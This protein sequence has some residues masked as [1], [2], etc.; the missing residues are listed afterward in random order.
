MDLFIFSLVALSASLHVL[1]N[2]FVKQS[3]DKMA[4]TY[5]ASIAGAGIV[6][7]IFMLSRMI[8]PGP[9]GWNVWGWAVLS[10]LFETLY[11][12]LLYQAYNKADIS[13]VYPLSRGTAP[14]FTAIIGFWFVGDSITV[15][16]GAAILVTII[17]VIS[18]SFSAYGIRMRRYS[19]IG[20]LPAVA[21][22]GM[23]ASYHLVDR[24]VMGS[25]NHPNSL[26]YFCI[27]R[28]FIAGF[29]TI[30]IMLRP[31]CYTIIIREWLTNKSGVIIAS[32]GIVSGYYLIIFALQYGNVTYITASRNIG[33][34]ISMIVGALFFKESG[35]RFRLIGALLITLGVISL[36]IFTH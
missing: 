19:R 27:V 21:T 32:F 34:V 7:P 29:L 3:V 9:L 12:I 28:L 35:S 4:F 23:I 33:I 16:S 20:I 1:W 10:G 5:L 17:G 30:W 14:V 24:H 36:V 22:G 13:V 8:Q 15:L 25:L 26:E 2:A 6:G 18:V 31:N 11:F